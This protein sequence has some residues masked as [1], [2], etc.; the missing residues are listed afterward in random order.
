MLSKVC[1]VAA[2]NYVLV[3]ASGMHAVCVCTIP[4]Y[5]KLM[6]SS[7]KLYDLTEKQIK[8]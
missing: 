4:Q 8:T 5:V 2:K 7:A 6:I 1:R 3:G